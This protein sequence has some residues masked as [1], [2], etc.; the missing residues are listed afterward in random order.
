MIQI[1]L[2][3]TSL[4]DY[5]YTIKSID[6][7]FNG[8]YKLTVLAPLG[9]VLENESIKI[10]NYDNF[11][12]LSSPI[13]EAVEDSTEEIC[14]IIKSGVYTTPTIFEYLPSTLDNEAIGIALPKIN[15]MHK[16][17][18]HAF[19]NVLENQILL[20]SLSVKK[21]FSNTTFY[22]KNIDDNLIAIRKSTFL[23]LGGFDENIKDL[24]LIYK[25][26][27]Y[28]NFKNSLYTVVCLGSLAFTRKVCS[29][30]DITAEDTARLN[31]KYGI[32]LDY[33][34]NSRSDIYEFINENP[35]EDFNILEVGC[36]TGATLLGFKNIYENVN[37]YGLEV[38][39]KCAEIAPP[40][41]H[42]KPG[43]CTNTIESFDDNSL[44]YIICDN[45]L[46]D[47]T[48]PWVFLRKCNKKLSDSGKLIANIPN[49][50][51][52]S[53]IAELL[54]GVFN[55]KESGVQGISKL[56][57]FTL[58][59]ML[60]LFT[61]NGFNVVRISAVQTGP[62]IDQEIIKEL[63]N[64]RVV[65]KDLQQPLEL[66]SQLTVVEYNLICTKVQE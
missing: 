28:T 26:Y 42:I 11:K 23:K 30:K 39:E 50:C 44:D 60:N 56:R 12:N 10:I 41:I 59:T 34:S 13:N 8:Q 48:D 63:V 17:Q 54:N 64:T 58:N 65:N 21:E 9:T 18:D 29:N 7:N 62:N 19:N 22:T 47:L 46:E 40:C 45:V 1:I 33:F 57:F 35:L 37:L 52:I 2:I 3:Y 51:H 38:V 24:P 32:V 25:D 43:D 55:Y 5:K 49:A 6:K 66:S 31:M 61:E 20:E 27:L 16:D 15:S 14:F 36:G 4:K 53:V